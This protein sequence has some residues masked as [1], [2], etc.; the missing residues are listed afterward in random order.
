[1]LKSLLIGVVALSAGFLIG[2]R[3]APVA[4]NSMLADAQMVAQ[5]RDVRY[6]GYFCGDDGA[7]VIS[8]QPP[9][10]CRNLYLLSDTDEFKA[11]PPR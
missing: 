7:T 5:D 4:V 1:M 8:R 2:S 10:E 11:P 9:T 6:I 3:N